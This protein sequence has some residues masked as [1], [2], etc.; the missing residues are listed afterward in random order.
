MGLAQDIARA[1]GGLYF[2]QRW[3]L[4]SIRVSVPGIAPGDAFDANDTFGTLMTFGNVARQLGGSFTIVHARFFDYDDEGTEMR[5]HLFRRPVTL[6]ASDA[7]WTIADTDLRHA[8]DTIAF[9]T[10][11]DHTA[12]QL[13]VASPALYIKCDADQAS[14]YGGL[15]CISTPN[16]AAGSDPEIELVVA[17]D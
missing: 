8:L 3:D 9:T 17:R 16:I 14:I 10:F 6:A 4:Q 7:A 12:G 2:T 5:L 11:R 13:G 15:Q 1:I